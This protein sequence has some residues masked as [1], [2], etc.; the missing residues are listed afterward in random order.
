[1]KLCTHISSLHFRD[2]AISEKL[3]FKWNNL[4]KLQIL[5]VLNFQ[6]FKKK[7]EI[8]VLQPYYFYA[9]SCQNFSLLLTRHVVSRDT[10]S[11]GLT[12][13]DKCDD[14]SHGLFAAVA[15]VAVDNSRPPP[16]PLL[17]RRQQL[18]Q[19]W[20]ALQITSSPVTVQPSACRRDRFT[21][22]LFSHTSLRS[23]AL[24][25][26]WGASDTP[27][28]FLNPSR[29]GEYGINWP[30]FVENDTSQN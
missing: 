30:F 5:G 10:D 27:T 28:G 19:L 20:S 3:I 23:P 9:F 29:V 8:V 22:F 26:F 13:P 1:M 25:T 12:S 2:I 16:P 18:E 11:A 14:L 15:G 6:N 21:R 17:P 4:E 24:V 7:S